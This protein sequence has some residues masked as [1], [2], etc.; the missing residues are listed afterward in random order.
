M[1]SM[2]EPNDDFGFSE[3][4]SSLGMNKVE[5]KLWNKAK[6]HDDR[7]AV[8]EQRDARRLKEHNEWEKERESKEWAQSEAGQLLKKLGECFAEYRNCVAK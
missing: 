3:D 8:L 5:Q 1:R 4:E 2:Y 6:D 7:V